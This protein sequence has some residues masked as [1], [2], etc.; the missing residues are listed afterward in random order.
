M[1]YLDMTDPDKLTSC[2]FFSPRTRSTSATTRPCGPRRGPGAYWL[3]GP[4][5]RALARWGR[6]RHLI[7]RKTAQRLAE[8]AQTLDGTTI[9]PSRLQEKVC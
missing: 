7:T 1:P 6:E 4:I 9:P 3:S 8:V 5:A 2:N